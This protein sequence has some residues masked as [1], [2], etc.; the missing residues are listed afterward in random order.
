MEGNE[1]N[2]ML[3]FENEYCRKCKHGNQF[4]SIETKLTC[5]EAEKLRLSVYT[6]EETQ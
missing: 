6:F 1:L 5:I 2:G 4:C 3:W